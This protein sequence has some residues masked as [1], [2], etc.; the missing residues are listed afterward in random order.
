MTHTTNAIARA[1]TRRSPATLAS[2]APRAAYLAALALLQIALVWQA[3]PAAGRWLV[4]HANL[5]TAPEP[6]CAATQLLLAAAAVAALAWSLA[7]P[8]LALLRHWRDGRSRFAGLPRAAVRVTHAGAIAFAL[9]V[10]VPLAVA[11]WPRATGTLV[12]ATTPLLPAGIALLIAGAASAEL[13]CSPLVPL[14]GLARARLAERRHGV[15][16]VADVSRRAA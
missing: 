2:H 7:L 8:L 5:G 9:S 13:L 1:H 15:R 14:A 12:H 16:A 4:A 10:V 3:L 11:A 6:V